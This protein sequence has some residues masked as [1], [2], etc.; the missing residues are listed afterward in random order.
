M[1]DQSEYEFFQLRK[2][3]KTYISKVFTFNYIQGL[4]LQRIKPGASPPSQNGG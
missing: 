3:A 1:S 4:N 2:E